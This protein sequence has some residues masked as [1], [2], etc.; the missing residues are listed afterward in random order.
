MS[1]N[2]FDIQKK[3]NTSKLHSALMLYAQKN[4]GELVFIDNILK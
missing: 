3:E 4:G 2:Y 1:I